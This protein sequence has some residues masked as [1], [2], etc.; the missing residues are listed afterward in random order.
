M[1]EHGS[2][3]SSGCVIATKGI[4]SSIRGLK[5]KTLRPD[6]VLLDDLQKAEDAENPAS[7]EKLLNIIKKDILNLSGKGKIA[8]LQTAT[9]IC[10]EDL[11]EKISH[12]TNWKT[13]I[14]PS[15]IQY[16]TDIIEHGDKGLW[17]KY[18]KLYDKENVADLNH[19]ESL[20]FYK[21]HKEEMDKG[22]EVFNPNRFKI[23]DGHISGL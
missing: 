1:N 23:S 19:D 18:F 3:P 7:V 4:S 14:F 12:D 9:P 5:H 21:E 15:I 13:S 10:C 6:L 22:S 16:P 8:C 17:G 20:N 2:L 11:T